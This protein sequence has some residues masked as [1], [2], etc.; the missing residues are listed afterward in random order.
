MNI[1]K[2]H[3]IIKMFE[4]ESTVLFY[5]FPDSHQLLQELFQ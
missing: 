5:H 2:T 1:H 3:Q 4:V